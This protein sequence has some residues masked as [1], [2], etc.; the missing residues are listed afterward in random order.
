MTLLKII[1]RKLIRPFQLNAATFEE[2]L[3]LEQRYSKHRDSNS[4][5]EAQ[6]RKLLKR[7]HPVNE[8]EKINQNLIDVNSLVKKIDQERGMEWLKIKIYKAFGV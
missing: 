2:A 8:N 1:F 3:E 6:A 7:L 4:F 5:H